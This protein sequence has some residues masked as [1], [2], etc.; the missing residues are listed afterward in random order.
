MATLQNEYV[1]YESLA[2]WN[3]PSSEGILISNDED[4]E[5]VYFY[6]DENSDEHQWIID[7]LK[8]FSLDEVP[9][10]TK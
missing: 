1:Q 2:A 8:E 9:F 7:R 5:G 10:P 6:V 3:T 4:G